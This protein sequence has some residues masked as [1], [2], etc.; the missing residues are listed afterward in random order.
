M[1]NDR[2]DT[3]AGR[4]DILRLWYERFYSSTSATANGSVFE[5]YMHRAMEARHGAS[6]SFSQVL[7]VGGNRGEH[8]PYVR[9]GFDR[10]V[11]SD[12]FPPDV[13]GVDLDPRVEAETADVQDLPHDAD[14][15]DRVVATCLLHHVPDPFAALKE[16]RRVVR[17][18]GGITLLV[19]TDPGWSYRTAQR[20]TSGRAARKRG[21]GEFFE[22]VHAVDHP[23]H[24]DSLQRQ[25]RY[26]FRHDRV[27]TTW[28]PLGVPLWNLNLFTVTDVTVSARP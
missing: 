25:V 16:L 7:E 26:V 21:I 24:F 12:L 14:S 6:V 4:E 23:N 2:D 22:L 9:H 15:F 3:F 5:R 27:R 1:T 8:V 10:Y 28:R 20:L 18:G 11:L 13:S 17:P 19:P